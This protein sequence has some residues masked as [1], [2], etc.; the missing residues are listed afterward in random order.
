ML[1]MGNNREETSRLNWPTIGRLIN[2]VNLQLSP[3]AFAPVL[4]A[5]V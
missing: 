4:T 2:R 5:T 3:A 1:L